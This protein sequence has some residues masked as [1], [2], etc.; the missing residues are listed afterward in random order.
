MTH[1]R[2]CLSKID[3]FFL[4]CLEYKTYQFCNVFKNKYGLF[5]IKIN[6]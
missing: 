5:V 1:F 2:E 6:I 3:Q 4:L